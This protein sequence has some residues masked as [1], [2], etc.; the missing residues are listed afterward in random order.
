MSQ[1]R[2]YQILKDL[3][4][5]ASSS[6]IIKEAEKRY[7]E[8]SLNKYA[9]VRLRSLE[10]K[11]VIDEISDEMDTSGRSLYWKIKDPD[12][13]GIPESQANKDFPDH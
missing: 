1:N 2:V 10:E 9:T 3:D 7:P 12:W 11:G 6:D 8:S 5:E 4:G 13:D